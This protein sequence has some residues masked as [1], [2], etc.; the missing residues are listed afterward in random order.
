MADYQLT[1]DR[2]LVQQLFLNN[3]GIARLLEQIVNQVLQAHV[4][5]QLQAQRYERTLERQGY[6]NGTRQRLLTTRVGQLTLTIPR[7][8][9]GSFSPELFA[10]LQRSEQALL[11]T[12]V[13]MV[14]QGVS[15]RKVSAVVEELCGTEVS[16]SLVSDLCKRLD[17]VVRDWNERDLSERV[18]PFVLVDALVIKVRKEHRIRIPSVLMAT[19][20][21]GEGCREVL[22][23]RIGDSES[24]ASWSDLFS[25]L[26]KR[27][28]RGVDLVVSDDHRGLV[29][30]V[31][32][33]FQ[34]ATWQRCQTHLMRNLM[35]ACPKAL[36]GELHARVRLIFE[37]PD[38]ATARRLLAE[39]V[40]DFGE[41][42]P[43]A[44]ER[45]EE[46]F[47]DA[48]AVLALPEPYRKRLRTTN[49]QER[50][51]EEIRRRERVIR[52]F[53]NVESAERLIGAL[54]MEQD[55]VWSTGRRYFDMTE[56]WAWK[57]GRDGQTKTDS[58]PMAQIAV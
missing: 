8:R 50:L 42:A 46:A 24:E 52:I 56:Y 58:A 4:T 29:K 22:G 16:K 33:H 3:G 32:T 2:D 18:Y 15:T 53:P 25:W 44:V 43:K 19:G 51:N 48:L 17:P 11:V 23:M 1:I 27:G 30:A 21:N 31:Q 40:N 28:L 35:D 38:L 57:R 39:L 49:G 55:E 5:E 36:Q 37:A 6:R 13:E 47:E 7:V 14:V 54:L 20:I 10:R 9:D 26:K 41:R 34:G 12:L 45:L